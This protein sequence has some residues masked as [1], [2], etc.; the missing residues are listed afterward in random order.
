MDTEKAIKLIKSMKDGNVPSSYSE[1]C[2]EY[3]EKL[4]EIIGVIEDG[5][6]FK[7]ILRDVGEEVKAREIKI[8]DEYLSKYGGAMEYIIKV[9]KERYFPPK[10]L[11][12]EQYHNILFADG[13]S[14][15]IKMIVEKYPDGRVIISNEA[16]GHLLEKGGET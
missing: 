14:I 8:P 6:K 10:A 12:H 11:K 16:E 9:V 7:E 4:N 3:N 13:E 1:F 5:Q 15:C 2:K